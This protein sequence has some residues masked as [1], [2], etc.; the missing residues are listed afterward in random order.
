MLYNIKTGYNG[1]VQRA[2][3]E[4]VVLVSS[5][6]KLAAEGISF[7]FTDR[8]A[9]LK[10]G[11]YFSDLRQLDELDWSSLKARNFRRD[12]EDPGRIERYQAEA[13]VYGH[14]PVRALLGIAC[15]SEAVKTELERV[16]GPIEDVP[17]RVRPNWYF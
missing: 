14:V 1:V 2:N 7:V 5:L 6:H 13:L 9:Y 3:D 10:L 17:I 8:H 11:N 15:H 16:V 4:I 12:L